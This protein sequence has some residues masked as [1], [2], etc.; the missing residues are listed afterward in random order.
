MWTLVVKNLT[1]R[2]TEEDLKLMFLK[3]N[4]EVV[5]VCMRRWNG[6]KKPYAFVRF[7]EERDAE[8]VLSLGGWI[9]DGQDLKVEWAYGQGKGGE[10]ECSSRDHSISRSSS[11]S[12]DKISLRSRS[13]SRSP[14]RIFRQVEQ[15]SQEVS[16][17]GTVDAFKSEKM[18]Q[19]EITEI[20]RERKELETKLK[21]KTAALQ[22]EVMG[23]AKLQETIVHLKVSGRKFRSNSEV[24]ESKCWKLLEETKALKAA[25][26]LLDRQNK[27][28]I[29][30]H[31]ELKAKNSELTK[32]QELTQEHEV[33]ELLQVKIED[34]KVENTKLK[35]TA[36]MCPN[37]GCSHT[38]SVGEL[39]AHRLGCS[40]RLVP[41][42]SVN[43]TMK[44]TILNMKSHLGKVSKKKT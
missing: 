36:V 22:Q 38:M 16:Y 1:S 7:Y 15:S 33:V 13:R 8:D 9:Q 28:H 24:A 23:K 30:E 29:I 14:I 39:G 41:C 6:R 31:E 18:D 25:N 19:A 4:R 10:G 26:C 12:S 3:H 32:M 21:E 34:L 37:I 42:P 2:T 5:D 20:V 27:N 44:A 43:C 35:N 40:S 11:G 17:V